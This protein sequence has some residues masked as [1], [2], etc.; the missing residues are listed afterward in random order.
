MI[1]FQKEFKD[2][3]HKEEKEKLAVIDM[4]K[5]NVM[6]RFLSILSKK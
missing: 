2:D 6:N 1:E 4:E 3:K 5:M